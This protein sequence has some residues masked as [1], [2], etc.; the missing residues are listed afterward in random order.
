M[1]EVGRSTREL[2]R[3]GLFRQFRY[4]T[5]RQA[6][7]VAIA[8]GALLATLIILWLGVTTHTVLLNSQLDTY[9]ARVEQI[10]HATNDVVSQLGDV[11]SPQKMDVRMR[12]A[13]YRLPDGVEF[14]VPVVAPSVATSSSLTTTTPQVGGN[15]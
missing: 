12:E 14:L 9:D 1:R 7:I 10:T 6:L 4:P 11:T 5:N 15:K 3:F 13:G 8:S 2:D